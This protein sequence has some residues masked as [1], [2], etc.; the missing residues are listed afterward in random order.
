MVYPDI[1]NPDDEHVCIANQP[2][3]T[4]PQ[5]TVC[6]DGLTVSNEKVIKIKSMINFFFYLGLS[7]GK[8]HSWNLG[9]SLVL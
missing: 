5:V 4:A 7:N 8:S 9:R 6:A 3:H 2:T 1:D